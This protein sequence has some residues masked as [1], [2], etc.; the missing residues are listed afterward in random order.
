MLNIA[1]DGPSG[2]GKSTIAKAIAKR[3]NILYLDTGAMYRAMGLKAVNTG[4]SPS[5]EDKVIP[6]LDITDIT[7]TYVDGIQHIF[8][9]GED[10]SEKIRE[11]HISKAAS[12][13]SK[14]PAVR[15]KLVDMQRKIAEQNNVIM[16]GRD[17]GS[18]VLPDAN[19]KFFLTASAE[20]RAQRRY[21]ELAAKG[22]KVDYDAILEDII[23]RDHNDSTRAF[24][25]LVK[26][27]DA[28]LIDNSNLTVSQSID[29]IIKEINK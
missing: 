15:L 25:P 2:A 18:Y 1:I 13:V 11:H 14:I 3:L 16:D 21:D 23:D 28:V 9:D 12:D 27:P 22:E 20:V 7:I 4:I 6:L 26:V 10:V 24:A 5:D 8:L 19:F 29:L 17:I